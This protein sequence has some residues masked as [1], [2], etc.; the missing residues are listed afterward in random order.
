MSALTVRH[1]MPLIHFRSKRE[2]RKNAMD[3]NR[4]KRKS[5]IGHIRWGEQTE[6]LKGHCNFSLLFVTR[7]NGNL[8]IILQM[9][10]Q[11]SGN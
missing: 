5:A 1:C 9:I 7:R 8:T 6:I 11:N 4:K 2:K 10:S 3:R